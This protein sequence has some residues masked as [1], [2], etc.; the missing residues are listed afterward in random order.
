MSGREWVPYTEEQIDYQP[1]PSL[2]V[3]WGSSEYIDMRAVPVEDYEGPY[4]AVPS[5]SDQ[6]FATADRY[7]TEDFSVT[8]IL[9]LEVTNDAGGL[10]LTI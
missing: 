8:S 7:M 3:A 2:Q 10:T 1:Q 6:T 5:W 9:E 4:S